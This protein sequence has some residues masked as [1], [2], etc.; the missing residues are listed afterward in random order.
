LPSTL[1]LYVGM[2]SARSLY[3]PPEECRASGC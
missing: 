3:R 1:N 2:I